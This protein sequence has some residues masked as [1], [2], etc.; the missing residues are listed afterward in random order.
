MIKCHISLGFSF[1]LIL[2]GACKQDAGADKNQASD[3][4]TRALIEKASWGNLPDGTAIDIYTLTNKNGLAAKI[5]N[6]GGI[7]V[8]LSTPDRNGKMEDVVLG[9]E[10]LDEYVKDNPYFGCIV[11]RY[12]NRIAN[13]QYDLGGKTYKLAKND[14][15]NHLHGGQKGFDKV[16][17]EAVPDT[18]K[19]EASLNLTYVSPDMEE[20]Y[21]GNLEVRVVY[22]LTNENA[23]KITYFATPDKQTHVNLTNHSYFNLT[24]DAK[25]DIL[26]HE[27]SLTANGFLPVDAGLIPTGSL[28]SL[29]GS[30]F[31]F[32]KPKKIGADI[33]A[34]H[35][36]LKLGQGYDHCWVLSNIQT[37]NMKNPAASLFEPTSG[38]YMEVYT[39]EPAIQFYSGNFL[40]GKY[41]GKGGVVYQDR[42]GLCLETQHFPDTPNRS[43]NEW[44]CTVIM[45]GSHYASTTIYKFSV[46]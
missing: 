25:R 37:A 35:E 3:K 1:L 9:Y 36:Q 34:G 26:D 32:R 23:L 38:R 8:S 24:G 2:L 13:G 5:T 30:A 20:G 31:D 4:K 14:G 10:T 33:N 28:T 39:T 15:E 22:T 29:N 11:G 44:P 17:W 19:G 45:P 18:S 40:D 46:R 16:V 21:P 7:V 42:W 43:Q 6:Y 12:A 41:K 27:L